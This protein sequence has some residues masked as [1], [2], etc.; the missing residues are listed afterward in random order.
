MCGGEYWLECFMFFWLCKW[1]FCVYFIVNIGLILND[2]FLS[3]LNFVVFM[4]FK[5]VLI[6]FFMVY[7]VN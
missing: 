6:I 5:L 4:F 7:L 2:K 3:W 1:N